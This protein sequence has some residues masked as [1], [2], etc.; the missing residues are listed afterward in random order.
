MRPRREGTTQIGRP[1]GL[2]FAG[3]PPVGPRGASTVARRRRILLHLAHGA[4]AVVLLAIFLAPTLWMLS[5]SFE[6]Q[7]S[8]F[9]NVSP[10]SIHTFVPTTAT[11]SNYVSAFE[12]S[13]VGQ[14]LL[15]SLIIAFAQVVLTMVLCVPAAYALARLRFRFKGLVFALIMVTFMVPGEVI[16]VPLFQIMSRIHLQNS[17][18]GVFLPWIA[19]PLGLYLVRQ[20]FLEVPVEYDEAARVDG[21]GHIRIMLTILLPL[22][23]PAIATLAIVTFLYSW[24]AFL[25]PLLIISSTS[26]QVIQ[27]AIA[28]NTVPGEIPNW[29]EVFAGAIVASIPVLVLFCGLQRYIVRGFT[30]SGLKG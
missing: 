24:N 5:S 26:K 3:Q 11:L 13:G 2:T 30:V 20:A 19:Y 14:A 12:K 22:I 17:L 1:H 16:V 28:V 9:N 10:L 18:P 21:C 29:G 25:W 15:N 4:T 6:P 7:T 23:R 27:V 8:I